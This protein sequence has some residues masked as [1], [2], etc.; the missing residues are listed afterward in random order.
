MDY[1]KIIEVL[2][3][4]KRF[5]FLSYEVKQE[6][7]GKMLKILFDEHNKRIN[8]KIPFDLN[9]LAEI[10]KD[11]NT[12][13][14]NIT[15]N[16]KEFEREFFSKKENEEIIKKIFDRYVFNIEIE[17]PY[18]NIGID[19]KDMIDKKDYTPIKEIC[20]LALKLSEILYMYMY[21]YPVNDSKSKFYLIHIVPIIFILIEG[22]FGIY[23]RALSKNDF[24]VLNIFSAFSITVLY[25]AVIIGLYYYF[26]IK[27][28]KNSGLFTKK[29]IPLTYSL[30][31]LIV[32]TYFITG[33]NGY[34]DNSQSKIYEFKIISKTGGDSHDLL[35]GSEEDEVFEASLKDYHKNIAAI[36]KSR[37]SV[38]RREF[39]KVKPGRDRLKVYMK[40]GRLGI[41]WVEKYEIIYNK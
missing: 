9:L 41:K 39:Y 19:I 24:Q 26:S 5:I 36:F 16:S 12:G 38:D 3:G 18:I 37:I 22:F 2:G 29:Q 13:I 20:D 23:I 30:I 1:N 40:N 14:I 17:K 11:V 10:S 8:I 27:F 31:W 7:N 25:M 35:L 28:I 21:A 32:S 15:S 33:I 6:Y 34:F 4:K